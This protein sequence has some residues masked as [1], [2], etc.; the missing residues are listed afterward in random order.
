MGRVA[1]T[2]GRRRDATARVHALQRL[3][4]RGKTPSK[5]TEFAKSVAL[6]GSISSVRALYDVE[7]IAKPRLSSKC[8]GIC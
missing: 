1:E 5:A 6:L 4:A 7:F 2:D 8:Y 3:R